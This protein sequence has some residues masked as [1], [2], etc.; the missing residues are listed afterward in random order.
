MPEILNDLSEQALVKA[1]EENMYAL[2]PLSHNWPDAEIYIGDDVSW[3]ITGV[4]FPTCN[5]IIHVRLKP[6]AVNGLLDRIIAKARKRKVNLHCW[7]AKDTRPANLGEYLTTHG[8]TSMGQAIGMAI[9]L[10]DMNEADRAPA[11]LRIIDVKDSADLDTW[12]RVAGAGFG[13]PEQAVP[14]VV[15]WLSMDIK[16]KQ[17]LK[18]Y[19]GLLD[20]KPVATSMYFLAEGVVGLY[21]V[22]TLPEARNKGIG[23][24]VTQKPLQDARE[25]GYKVGILQASKMGK[26]CYLRLGFKE[27]SSLGSYSWIYEQNKGE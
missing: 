7:V 27:Y 17:P 3:C 4:A 22:A 23:F 2:T 13:I 9:A 18:L 24:A 12:C 6:E 21:F 10:S 25:M 16:M 14:S 8:F 26:P 5:P 11:G 19:L 20:G 15:Q 1:I